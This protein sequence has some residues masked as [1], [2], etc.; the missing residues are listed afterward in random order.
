[1]HAASARAGA[2]VSGLCKVGAHNRF[3]TTGVGWQ[4][5]DIGGSLQTVSCWRDCGGGNLSSRDLMDGG[6]ML[7]VGMEVTVVV[8]AVPAR[9][10]TAF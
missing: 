9:D 10:V 6:L 8:M 5:E 2:A 3:I 1:V 7:L 4:A